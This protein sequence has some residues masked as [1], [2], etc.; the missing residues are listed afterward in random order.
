MM[1]LLAASLLHAV[2][3]GTE[4]LP[5]ACVKVHALFCFL[6]GVVWVTNRWLVLVSAPKN[7]LMTFHEALLSRDD[8][9]V[10]WK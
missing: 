8:R 3:F 9:H 7:S 6:Q 10:Q 2:E 5:D 1:C 4:T